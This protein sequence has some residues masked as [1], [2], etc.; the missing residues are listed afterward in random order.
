M[1]LSVMSQKQHALNVKSTAGSWNELNVLLLI[2][3]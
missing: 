3:L 2:Y 1:Q